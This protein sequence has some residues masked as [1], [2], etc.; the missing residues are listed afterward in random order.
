[1]DR[2]TVTIIIEEVMN[3]KREWG[4]KNTGELRQM[5]RGGWK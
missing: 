1:M 5:E 2:Q 4:K 3:L